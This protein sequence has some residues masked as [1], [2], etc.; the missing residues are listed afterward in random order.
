MSTGRLDEIWRNFATGPV[1]RFA[2][3]RRAAMP[4]T[5]P[6][7]AAPPA[8]RGSLA[9]AARS[10]SLAPDAPP[11]LEGFLRRARARELLL[12]EALSVRV[13]LRPLEE[14][15]RFVEDLRVFVP[16]LAMRPPLRFR[17]GV[18]IPLSHAGG[19]ETVGPP[20][21]QT[22]LVEAASSGR[23]NLTHHLYRALFR[24]S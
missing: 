23:P 6:A 15:L 12:L 24:G 4:P 1:D 10:E 21:S 18:R 8:I 17:S 16:C 14:L 22:R 20:I 9:L 3:R 2:A 5:A 11:L 13:L 7:S 19:P